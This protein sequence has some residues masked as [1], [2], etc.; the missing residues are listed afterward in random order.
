[1]DIKVHGKH[2]HV[3]ES[4]EFF[5]TEKVG[6]LSK[7]LPT[8]T[9]IEVELYEEGKIKNHN[10]VA[11]VTVLANGPSFRAKTTSSDHKACIDIA[12][13]RLTRQLTDFNRKRSR[14]PAHARHAKEPAAAATIAADTTLEEGNSV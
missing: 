7:F 1:M 11:E 2:S 4:L 3:P 10:H 6:K 13:E 5:A 14:K 8:I 12:V 9:Y